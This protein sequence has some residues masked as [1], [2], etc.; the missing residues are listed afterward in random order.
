MA[1]GATVLGP[2]SGSGLGLKSCHASQPVQ[3]AQ[4]DQDAEQCI[5]APFEPTS[6]RP[7]PTNCKDK[8]V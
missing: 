1:V 3:D 4:P 6:G 5:K 8:M 7:L 2:P